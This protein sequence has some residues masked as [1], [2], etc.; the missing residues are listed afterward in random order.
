MIRSMIHPPLLVALLA[1]TYLEGIPA[2]RARSDLDRYYRSAA[3]PSH[4]SAALE[5]LS[6]SSP[7]MRQMGSAYLVALYRDALEDELSGRIPWHAT[8]FWGGPSESDAREFRSSLADEIGEHA[9]GEEAVAV[10]G[11]A[12]RHERA[13]ALRTALAGALPRLIGPD[14][15][16]LIVSLLSSSEGN[17]VVLSQALEQVQARKLSRAK[18]DVLRLCQ[19]PRPS[20]S[21]SARAVAASSSWPIPDNG[22][23]EFPVWLDRAL[24]NVRARVLDPIPPGSRWAV[25]RIHSGRTDYPDSLTLQTLGGWWLAERDTTVICLDWFGRQ[26]ELP[27]MR[28]EVEFGSFAKA[29]SILVWART[30]SPRRDYDLEER[31]R[32]ILSREGGL[33]AQFEAQDLSVPEALVAAWAQE[34]GDRGAATAILAP[35]LDTLQDGRDFDPIVRD[36][37]GTIY[38]LAMLDRFSLDRDYAET[39]RIARHLARPEFDGY[40]YQSRARELAQQLPRR[41]TDFGSFRLPDSAS[42]SAERRHLSREKQIAFLAERLRLL[43]CFQ[44]GQP[45][46]VAFWGP[47]YAEATHK[48]DVWSPIRH[49]SAPAINP[50][51][52]LS[53]MKLGIDDLPALSPFVLDRNFTLTY[54]FWRDFNPDRTLYRVNMLVAHR[55]QDIAGRDLVHLDDFGKLSE[56]EQRERA[57]AVARWARAHH[58]WTVHQ[59]TLDC[60]ATAD[61]WS[62]FVS[63][64]NQAR[65]DSIS[66]AGPIVLSR[67]DHFGRGR[68]ILLQDACALDSASA[69]ARS[70]GLLQDAD[71]EVRL[72]AARIL[73]RRGGEDAARGVEG[74][75]GLKQ[76]DPYRYWAVETFYDLLASGRPDAVELAATALRENP[77]WR[78]GDEA[79]RM[80]Q[81]LFLLGRPEALSYLESQLWN[82]VTVTWVADTS[83]KLTVGVSLQDRTANDLTLWRKDM[84][85]LSP[86]APEKERF[87]RRMELVTWLH[88]Q[89]AAIDAHRPN[90]IVPITK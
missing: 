37:Q 70:R 57:A 83:G 39:I 86:T 76:A 32:A 44:W 48:K 15:D 21:R 81:R 23:P 46:G 19:D 79:M 1:A 30:E 28:T 78:G 29:E 50:W 51:V 66:A 42:W 16:A 82:P 64:V 85:P 20:V 9:Q 7:Y 3:H 10:V 8:P 40:E 12:L 77:Y 35:R 24:R 89:F 36:L 80:A 73:L 74:V 56:A 18:L 11:W 38:H 60:L 4:S 69:A 43:N 31:K 68:S 90:D 84:K 61:E 33:T 54:E 65:Q 55:I 45:G 49:R 58:G 25:F 13:T 72:A 41:A 88:D 26:T 62:D 2:Q 5:W 87:Q 52:E 59:L 22:A 17:R 34:R 67:M 27:R 53:D 47:Q 75:R 14:A 63:A 71:S 6:S